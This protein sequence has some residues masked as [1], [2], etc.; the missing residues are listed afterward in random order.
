[1]DILYKMLQTGDMDKG[2]QNSETYRDQLILALR[3]RESVIADHAW[4]D[5]DSAAHL[6]ALIAV[7]HKITELA[8]QWR[9]DPQQALPARLNHFLEGCSY[10]KALAYLEGNN[11]ACQ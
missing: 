8:S 2:C 4:R 11:T 9:S 5:R 6:Q 1:M 10:Q 7:S 3:E